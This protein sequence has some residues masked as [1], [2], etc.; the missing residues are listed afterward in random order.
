M[1]DSEPA[2]QIPRYPA[3]DVWETIQQNNMMGLLSP[4]AAMEYSAARKDA[5]SFR[6]QSLLACLPP[7]PA[8][9]P[10]LVIIE[11]LAPMPTEDKT[12]FKL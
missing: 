8:L 4:M 3:D 12:T 9:V 2:A 6:P 1:S 7:P 10:F 11:K 5:K